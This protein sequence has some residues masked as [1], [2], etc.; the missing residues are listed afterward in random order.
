M[1]VR[2]LGVHLSCDRSWS[3]HI[4]KIVQEAR[5][6]SSW[7]LSVFRD[8]SPLPMLTLYK[9]M[10]RSK[11]EYCCPVW[12]P[13]KVSDIQALENIQRNFTKRIAGCGELNYW[14]RL[15]KLNLMSLQ[16]RRERYCIIHTWKILNDLAP[17]DVSLNFNKHNRRGIKITLPPLNHKTQASVR[18]DYE[19]SFKIRAARLWN[20]LPQDV[21]SITTLDA[22]KAALGR[23][24]KKIPDTPSTPG[25]TAANRNS[26]LDWSMNS[27]MGC[28]TGGRA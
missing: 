18:T 12:N 20:L 9:S 5:T 22:F 24:L 21:N 4:D 16:R 13:S 2:D 3:P 8:R 17:N 14:D 26:L 25:Y 23:Y 28:S 10:V 19:N 11:L 7:V 6:I 15:K 27:K 1:V